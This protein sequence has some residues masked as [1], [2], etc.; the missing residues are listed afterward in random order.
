MAKKLEQNFYRREDVV[1]IAKD[2]LGKVIHT[3]INGE[4]TAAKIVE[5]EAYS[6]TERACHAYNRRRTVRTSV[7]YKEGGHAYVYLIY[8]MYELFNIVTNIEEEPEAVLI[9]GVEPLE[10]WDIMRERRKVPDKNLTSGP[11]KLTTAMGI[12]RKLNGISLLS[13]KI[14]LEEDLVQLND[15]SI[16]ETTRVGVDYAE[17]DAILPWRFYVKDNPFVSKK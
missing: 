7:M 8:G 9:R 11:G 13:D 14:W 17:E 4:Y 2:L 15:K 6:H 3:N 5:T 1:Q 10:G 16:V 12:D